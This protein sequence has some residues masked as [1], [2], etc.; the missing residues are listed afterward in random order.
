MMKKEGEEHMLL[1]QIEKLVEEAVDYVIERLKSSNFNVRR[2]DVPQMFYACMEILTTGL[3]DRSMLSRK[4]LRYLEFYKFFKKYVEERVWY[5]VWRLFD[6]RKVKV[7]KIIVSDR[8]GGE[9]IHD[10]RFYMGRDIDLLL[11]VEDDLER[12][13]G[14]A[15]RIED[16]LNDAVGN[17]LQ[18]IFLDSGGR[19][20][21]ELRKCKTYNLFEIDVYGS[22][23]E[24]KRWG[25]LK[26]YDRKDY[27]M[28]RIDETSLLG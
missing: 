27:L 24:A 11:V 1:C 19:S 17:R 23:T 26:E 18:K 5:I 25:Y 10:S 21:E 15:I 16:R 22:E 8:M 4:G 7:R 14:E 6:L 13:K 3:D 28:K 2:K 20:P 12:V 9:G